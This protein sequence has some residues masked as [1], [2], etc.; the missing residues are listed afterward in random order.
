[1]TEGVQGEV[2]RGG[3]PVHVVTNSDMTYDDYLKVP[4]LLG[5]Q[6]PLSTP[7][8]HDELL[9]IVIHQAYELW[10]KLILH[11]METAIAC[12]QQKQVLR[13]HHFVSRIVRVMQ[14]LVK[15]IHIL[16]TMTPVEFLEFRDSMKPASGFQSIQ[17]R[18]IEYLA[19]LKG[20][21][22]EKYLGF[23]RNRPD[24]LARLQRRLDQPDL[25][26]TYYRL[27]IQLGYKIPDAAIA[28]EITDFD[29]A[30]KQIIPGVLPIYQKPSEHLELYLLSESL[31]EMD[32]YFILWREHHMHVV[33]RVIGA[34]VG[35]GGS[36]GVEYLRS[37]TTKKFFPALWD[38]RTHIK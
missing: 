30:M 4:E 11:E 21:E 2:R 33:E 8:H 6:H 20:P 14:L 19:G 29:K 17:F 18:E 1:M 31:V 26:T 12:M 10:F 36:Q 25:K 15:Q 24:F 27:L 16:E 28:L 34:K 32:E 22:A 9:F 35:T 38:V 3:C 37:T 5:M 23:F 7:P 13:A